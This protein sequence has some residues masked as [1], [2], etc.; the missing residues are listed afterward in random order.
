MSRNR[1]EIYRG[2]DGKWWWRLRS[3]GNRIGD[4]SHQGYARK[5]YCRWRAKRAYPGCVVLE[6]PRA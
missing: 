1:L 3:P 4:A 5:W 6:V 2:H